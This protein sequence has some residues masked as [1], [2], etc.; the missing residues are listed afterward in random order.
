MIKR[1]FKYFHT[2]RYLR[3]V[4]I[5]GRLWFRIYAPSM[6]VIVSPWVSGPSTNPSMLATSQFIFLNG[7]GLTQGLGIFWVMRRCLVHRVS[8]L[9]GS[10][11][12]CLGGFLAGG[13]RGAT[14]VPGPGGVGI[15]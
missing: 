14:F 4:Q 9:L 11:P 1:G 10:L 13:G 2:L 7:C 6:R 8:G 3:S 15:W 12:T 5:Y